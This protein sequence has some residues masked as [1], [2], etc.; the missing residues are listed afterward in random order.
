MLRSIVKLFR[1]KPMPLALRPTTGTIYGHVHE[2]S[3]TGLARNLFWNI[4]I[5]FE[6]VRQDGEDWDCSLGIE[7]LTWPV[8]SWRDLDGMSLG[9][10]QQE[11]LLE[12]SLYLFAA[13]HPATL[14]RLILRET[15]DA[16]FEADFS[17]IADVH[18]PEGSGRRLFE[19]NGKCHLSFEGIVVVPDNL[20]PKPNSAHEVESAVAEF[21][22]VD[23]LTDPRSE[24]LRFILKPAV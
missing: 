10:V 20:L 24:G 13:H 5:E 11:E 9:Q 12:C 14:R 18:D 15:A 6:P 2:N 23:D 3:H 1:S 8:R 4:E 22:A 19:V 21:L 7:W 17:A 16:R